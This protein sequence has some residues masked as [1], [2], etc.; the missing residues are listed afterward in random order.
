MP[1][2]AKPT[3][4]TAGK[5]VNLKGTVYEPGDAVTWANLKGVRN[6]SS[7]VSARILIPVPGDPHH[8]RTILSCPT[9]TDMPA[10]VLKETIT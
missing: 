6:V 4:F 7:L 8:R 5:R 2:F 1:A 10:S 9:P 3:S